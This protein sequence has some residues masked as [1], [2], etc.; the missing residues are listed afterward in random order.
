MGSHGGAAAPS[1]ASGAVTGGT[2]GASAGTAVVT[3][4]T[5]AT[6]KALAVGAAIGALTTGGTVAVS[7][8][9]EARTAQE[10]TTAEHQTA[11]RAESRRLP[12]RPVPGDR[13]VVTADAPA[14]DI[15]ALAAPTAPASPPKNAATEPEP[16][17]TA[18][19]EPHSASVAAFAGAAAS[20][21]PVGSDGARDEARLV[22]VAREALTRQDP[23]SAL[24]ALRATERLYPDGI[25][26]Q[27]REALS[28]S[29]L[30]ALGRTAEAAARAR[31]F[32]RA[33][34]GSPHAA[35]AR[36]AL[37]E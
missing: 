22:G 1:S 23:A 35:R 34:P 17:P 11:S 18:S 14:G 32:L 7:R 26:L 20:A 6:M 30:S 2:A 5:I 21:A 8:M 3:G 27:E 4:G 28:I 12:P 36:A 10:T 13:S 19:V 31:A 25:L 16:G 9:V 15:P 37:R 24:V 33:F 29:A